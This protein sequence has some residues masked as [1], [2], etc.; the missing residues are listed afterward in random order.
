MTIVNVSVPAISG[1]LGVTTSEGTWAISSYMLAAAIM[2]PL[3][4][5]IGR[6]FGEVR[7]FVTSILLFMCLLGRVRAGHQPADAGRRAPHP[8]PGFRTHD[9]GGAGDP[10]AQLSDRA[11]RHGD[12]AVVHGD[13]HRAHFRPHHRRLDHRQSVLALAVLHQPARG[14]LLGRGVLV[15]PAPPRVEEGETAHRRHRA[16]PAGRGRGQPAV[17]AG[18]RQREGLVQLAGHPD[19]GLG[20]ADQRELPHSLGTHRQAPGDR[21]AFVRAAQFPGRHGG[22]RRRLFRL[23]RGQRHLPPVAANHG[24]LHGHLGGTGGG[25][26]SACWPWWRRPSWAAI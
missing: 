9:V 12:R 6:R 17:H 3:T 16:R 24:R 11:A 19:R 26:R 10:A 13:H 25:A 4:G 20:L 15:D 7:T 5:W 14:R 8:G 21:F 23:V 22:H 18:Q 1:S 2:Q